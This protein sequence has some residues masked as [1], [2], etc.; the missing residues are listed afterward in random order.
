MSKAGITKIK[1]LK[2]RMEYITVVG[3]VV[4]KSAVT[5]LGGKKYAS[6]IIEDETGKIKLNLWRDQ[7]SQVEEGDLIKISKAFVHQRNGGRQLS[8]WEKIEHAS[9]RDLKS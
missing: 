3:R 2:H 7:V 4:M 1:D 5:E 8:T 9:L 6:A